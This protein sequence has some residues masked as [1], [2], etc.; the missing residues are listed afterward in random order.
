MKTRRQRQMR[1]SRKQK[2]RSRRQRQKGGAQIFA[3]FGTIDKTFPLIVKQENTPR[4]MLGKLLE[5]I[6]E[7]RQ[8][9]ELRNLTKNILPYRIRKGLH[10]IKILKTKENWNKQNYFNDYAAYTFLPVLKDLN[11]VKKRSEYEATLSLQIVKNVLTHFKDGAKIISHSSATTD[12]IQKNVNQ[13]FKFDKAPFSPIVLIDIA[14]FDEI[15]KNY[16]FYKYLEFEEFTVPGIGPPSHVRFYKKEAGQPLEINPDDQIDPPISK[17]EK[18]KYLEEVNKQGGEKR[19][20]KEEIVICC[21]KHD[22]TVKIDSL[23]NENQN[24]YMWSD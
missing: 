6:P 11:T 23:L 2:K 8:N 9:S 16:N 22:M 1:L 19:L 7:I 20:K 10:N 13:Q 14:F 12:N 5:E 15:Q 17:E 3:K 18:I 24:F 21:I 4:T